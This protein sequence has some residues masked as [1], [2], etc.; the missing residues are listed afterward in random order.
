M[1]TCDFDESKWHDLGQELGLQKSTL[2]TIS[3]SSYHD[4]TCL[5][6]CLFQWVEEAEKKD[7]E[8]PGRGG[9]TWD[10]LSDALRSINEITVADKLDQESEL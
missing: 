6:E 10:S 1:K 2:E 8:L 7:K 5:F 4:E 3:K 9:A